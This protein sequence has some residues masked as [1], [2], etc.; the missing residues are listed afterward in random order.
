M[1][2]IDRPLTG[3]VLVFD[4]AQERARALEGVGLERSGRNGRTLLKTDELRVTLI[5]LAPGGEIPEHHAEGPINVQVIDGSIE[6]EAGDEKHALRPGQLLSAGPGVPH[7]VRSASG[8]TFLLTVAHRP[9]GR[10]QA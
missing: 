6:F 4:L 8:G 5:V 2:S 9:S 3:E 1:S 10:A 7:A